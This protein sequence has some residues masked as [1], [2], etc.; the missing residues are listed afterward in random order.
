M[1]RRLFQD[2]W[3]ELLQPHFRQTLTAD[4][5]AVVHPFAQIKLW[6]E[7]RQINLIGLYGLRDIEIGDDATLTMTPTVRLLFARNISIGGNGR[8]A[9]ESGFVR[10][11]CEELHGPFHIPTV[12]VKGMFGFAHEFEGIER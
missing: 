5:P 7:A 9:F 2:H 8:L 1:R 3:I 6:I 4:N 10:A 12:V 11:T